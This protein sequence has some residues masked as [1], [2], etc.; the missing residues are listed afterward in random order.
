M[1]LLPFS[2]LSSFTSHSSHTLLLPSFSIPLFSPP[3]HHIYPSSHLL[4][5][6]LLSSLNQVFINSWTIFLIP[7]TF[8]L[9][10][11]FTFTFLLSFYFLLFVLLHL[12]EPH[13]LCFYCFLLVQ[14]TQFLFYFKP[15]L[16]N[17]C[18]LFLFT[19]INII[20]LGWI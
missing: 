9:Y 2:F 17:P 1:H 15:V 16:S 3:L 20:F 13:W 18:H 7:K 8:P 5:S 19:N 12:T 11:D 6:L 14:P 4:L 10:Q